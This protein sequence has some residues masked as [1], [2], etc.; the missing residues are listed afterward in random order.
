[1]PRFVK[2]VSRKVG[3]PPGTL[4]HFGEKK[5]EEVRVTLIHYD[6]AHV[7]EKDLSRVEESFP[8]QDR[9]IVTWLNITGLHRADIVEKV[10]EIVGLHPLL[11]E[12]IL[13]TEQHP[14]MEDFG[15]YLFVVLKM[16]DY[17]EEAGEVEAEQV[18]LVLGSSYLITFQERESQIFQPILERIR[19]GKGRIRTMGADYLAYALLDAVIDHY[20]VVLEKL[21]EKIESVED[22]LVT[23]PVKKTLQQIQDLKREMLYVRRSVWHLREVLSCLERG[24]SSLIS[25]S[26]Q[27]YFK[28][29]YDHTIQVIDTVEMLRDMLSGMLDIYLSSVSNRLN[30]VMKVL[31]IIATIFIPLTFVVGI[32]GMNFKHM[33]ELEWRWGYPLIWL[34]M[35]TMALTMVAYFKRKKWF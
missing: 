26:T 32:Y 5:T 35:V 20:F 3:L 17:R 22:D 6:E 21:G 18:S 15:D 2:K 29:V 30:E 13:T 9:P 33:P 1:M 7:E 8:F 25:E 14:K 24:E 23:H 4:V 27:I 19:N 31:T 28:D 10:G 34:V 16:L 11:M 12:D